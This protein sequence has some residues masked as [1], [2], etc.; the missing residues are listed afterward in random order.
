MTTVPFTTEGLGDMRLLYI[1]L[2]LFKLILRCISLEASSILLSISFKPYRDSVI[3]N[4]I[5]V[6]NS[7]L[8]E[9]YSNLVQIDVR[10]LFYMV[11]SFRRNF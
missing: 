3:I 7:Q 10:K 11:V 8:S 4:V 5:V 9:S 6:Y 2:V 1:V